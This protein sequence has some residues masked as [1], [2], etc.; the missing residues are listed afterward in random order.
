ME[1]KGGVE[2]LKTVAVVVPMYR[3]RLTAD[4]EVSYRHLMRFLGRYDKYFIAPESLTLDDPAFDVV[5]F[6]DEF[7]RDTMT[8]SALL[9]SSDFYRAFDQY[10]FILI[11]QL[12]ALVFSDQLQEWCERG[13]D[14]IGAPWLNCKD[15]PF[16]EEPT[17]GNGG[18]SLRKVKSFLKVLSS[19]R[20][21]PELHRYRDALAGRDNGTGR[22]E[23]PSPRTPRR[24]R[25]A[26]RLG[27]SNPLLKGILRLPQ[28]LEISYGGNEDYFWSFHAAKYYRGFQIAPAKEG[29]RFSFE[30]EPRRCYE[31]NHYRLPFGCH[32]WGRYDRGFW[33]PF[34]LK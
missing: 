15:A 4:E 28:D 25:L 13:W 16:V 17:V 19:W 31:L 8:Y 27:L 5:R 20:F 6:G 10:E 24:Y 34:L 12:D 30:V 11:Y 33:E 21:G 3:E 1:H 7:F 23:R 2:S 26:G 18:F 29:L 32:A 14:Y 22:G 9:L